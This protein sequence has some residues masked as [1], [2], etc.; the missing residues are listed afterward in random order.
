MSANSEGLFL[1]RRNGA[2]LLLIAWF[3]LLVAGC[4]DRPS[5][6]AVPFSQQVAE[7][8]KETDAGLRAKRLIKIG[9]MQGKARDMAGAEETLRTAERDCQTIGDAGERAAALALLAEAYAGLDHKSAAA[10]TLESAAAATADET[11]PEN[12]G[13]CAG[14]T[15]SGPNCRRRHCG[16]HGVAKGR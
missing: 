6:E 10:R 7:A 16:R 1:M 9:Y 2:L 12:R 5:T 13:A 3:C 8:Q 4:N 15:G 14:E 11:R